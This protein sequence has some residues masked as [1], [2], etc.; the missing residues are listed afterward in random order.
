MEVAGLTSAPTSRTKSSLIPTS[1]A[2][3]P[4]LESNEVDRRAAQWRHAQCQPRKEARSSTA[5]NAGPDRERLTI[6]R[7]GPIGI[8]HG[9][10]DVPQN[11][12]VLLPGELGDLVPDL[13]SS[14]RPIEPDGPQIPGP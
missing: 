10:S 2:A 9:D 14:P 12:V 7:K 5:E 1:A 13:S 6:Q 4:T 11:E 3:Q 8:A